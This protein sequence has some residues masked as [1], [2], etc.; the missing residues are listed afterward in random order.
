M[1]KRKIFCTKEA[2]FSAL[3]QNPDVNGLLCHLQTDS[4]LILE[5]D[6]EGRTL[7]HHAVYNYDAVRIMEPFITKEALSTQ[8]SFGRTPL[9]INMANTQ[10][11]HFFLLILPLYL[12]KAYETKFDFTMRDKNRNAPLHCLIIYGGIDKYTKKPRNM[13]AEILKYVPNI[14]LNL[15]GGNGTSFLGLTLHFGLY[16]AAE[17]LL[18]KG[19]DPSI[20]DE[21]V[22]PTYETDPYKIINKKIELAKDEITSVLNKISKYKEQY[23]TRYSQM[24]FANSLSDELESKQDN[25][26]NLVGIRLKIIQ[27]AIKARPIIFK[28]P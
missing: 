22:D 16:E 26:S 15:I 4:K 11:Y 14:N 21:P 1:I 28:S 18:A 2:F 7:L 25:V 6:E 19:V 10:S 8:D 24:F 13:V 9:H 27:A 3:I 5:Q 23:G 20:F 17:I 12:K